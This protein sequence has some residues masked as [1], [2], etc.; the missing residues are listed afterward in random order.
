MKLKYFE[1]SCGP[2]AVGGKKNYIVYRSKI[3]EFAV[4]KTRYVDFRAKNLVK[5]ATVK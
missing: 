5:I 1:F 3:P 2:S 4:K